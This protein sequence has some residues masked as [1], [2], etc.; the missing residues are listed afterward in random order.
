ME[1]VVRDD[2]VL[3]WAEQING[4]IKAATMD[5]GN[6]LLEAKAELKHGEWQQLVMEHLPF[7]IRTAQKMMSIANH[8]TLKHADP[9]LLPTSTEK[10]YELSRMSEE[11]AEGWLECGSSEDEDVGPWCGED[12]TYWVD[13]MEYS[14]LRDNINEIRQHVIFLG[15]F[16]TDAEVMEVLFNALYNEKQRSIGEVNRHRGVGR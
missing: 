4:T 9:S 1:L 6:Y 15:I 13:F 11:K 14:F 5:I 8:P 2:K 12:L 3:F 10:L 16:L 7:S